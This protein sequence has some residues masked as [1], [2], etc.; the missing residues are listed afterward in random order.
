MNR[1]LSLFVS[2]GLLA[3]AACGGGGSKPKPPTYELSGTITRAWG[4]ALAGVAVDLGGAATGTVATDASGRFTFPSVSDGSYTVT[5][6]LAGWVFAPAAPTVVVS[7]A[8]RAQD[9]TADGA[10]TISGA[11]SGAASGGV[12]VALSG[13]GVVKPAATSAPGTG[14]YAFAGIPN[15]T[16]TLTPAL[17]GFTFSPAAPAVAVDGAGATQDFVSAG[18]LQIAGTVRDG[19]GA[20]LAG[21]TVRLGGARTAIATTGAGGGYAF[22][23]LAPGQSFTVRPATFGWSFDPASG[24]TGPASRAYTLAASVADADFAGQ[25]AGPPVHAFQ[26]TLAYGGS[27]TGP[28]YVTVA[29][30]FGGGTPSGGT[31]LASQAGPWSGRAFTARNVQAGGQVTV[32]AWMDVLGVG[33]FVAG[34]DP[35]VTVSLDTATAGFDVGALT[36]V[37]PPAPAAAAG[38]ALGGVV[39]GDGMVVVAFQPPRTAGGDLVADGFRVYWNVGA[40]VDAAHTLGTIT[41]PAGPD[42][43]AVHGL[44]NG[45]PYWFAV[46][47]WLGGAPLA[48]QR[49][50]TA[51][52]V[53]PGPQDGTATISGTVSHPAVAAPGALYV[54][55]QSGQKAPAGGIWFQRLPNPAGTQTSYALQLPPGTYALFA[56]VDVGDDGAV[57]FGEP[58]RFPGNGAVSFFTAVAGPNAGPALALTGAGA[59]PSITTARFASSTSEGAGLQLGVT[60]GARLPV[61]AAI[62]GPGLRG[63]LDLGLLSD[64][65]GAGALLAAFFTTEPISPVPGDT[66]ALQVTYA[67][68]TTESFQQPIT[69]FFGGPPAVVAPADGATGVS[70]TPAFQWSAPPGGSE[71]T[72]WVLEVRSQAGDG[73]L[74]GTFL[75][76]S[77]T[78]AIFD[79]DGQASAPALLAF[80]PCRW[81]LIA[82]DADGNQSGY[83][84]TFTTGASSLSTYDALAGAALDGQRW[85]TPQLTR[86]AEGGKAVLG[87]RADDMQARTVRGHTYTN[88]INV[89]AGGQR[90]TTF[91]A[92][93]T[94]PTA[95]IGRSYS[96]V[97]IGGIRLFYQ[98]SL[99]R[100]QPFPTGNGNMLIAA[101]ELFDDG[102]GLQL[103]RRFYHCDDAPCVAFSGSG[104]TTADPPGFTVDGVNGVTAAYLDSSYVLELSLDEVS[105]VF[106]WTVQGGAFVTPVSGTADVSAWASSVGMAL[107]TTGNGFSGAHL[108]SR[109]SDDVG[110]SGGHIAPEFDDVLVGFN[111]AAASIWDDF[112][113]GFFDPTRWG[114]VDSDVWMADGSLHLQS[115]LTT[116]AAGGGSEATAV[117]VMYPG[118]FRAWQV[119]AAI[120]AEHLGP[121]PDSVSRAGMIGAFYNDGTPG[122]GATG[123]V[124]ASLTITTGS[125][126]WTIL[127]CG[128]PTCGT[129]T[130][131]GGTLSPSASHPLGLGTMHTLGVQWDAASRRFTFTID[132]APPVPVDPTVVLPTAPVMSVTPRYPL[133]MLTSSV[134][135]GSAAPAASFAR[136]EATFANVRTS[137]P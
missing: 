120:A 124:R 43:A 133:H 108:F 99:D 98:R 64:S 78:S 95:T 128:N 126:D 132:D 118:S 127:R 79:E 54:V 102:G 53:T 11:V 69:G 62:T 101:L 77:R 121:P 25:P 44:A 27:K 94:V 45:T 87:V 19:G 16:Y 72:G 46:E 7:G 92:T 73:D 50:V 91:G 129:V 3:L 58:A 8:A 123:D 111:G 20:P 31:G 70:T 23:G 71:V 112:G 41:V 86:S 52:P 130:G 100:G 84:A 10:Y 21:M 74:W 36:L 65:G 93:L 35:S 106:T 15:G 83:E 115:E 97:A 55:A 125:V 135:I 24:V 9:F 28:V 60:S 17:A 40:T 18:S 68:G 117:N 107:G 38:L 5:P 56:F 2:V 34:A 30:P 39:P 57:G 49:A 119:D 47:A 116:A 137:P 110:G 6:R 14:A 61:S 1:R 104:I 90:V 89:L 33:K 80:T 66:Y 75:P 113:A 32:R 76:G 26:G 42:F 37:D 131:V 96:A 122:T 82:M 109:V 136:V 29:G 48:G 67:N 114:P 105:G 85:Q 13:G 134:F 12:T 59:T 103:R 22:T 81:N 63:P 51:A 88:F 4:G